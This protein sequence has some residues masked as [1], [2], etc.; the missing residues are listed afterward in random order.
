MI[1]FTPF[2]R[3][4]VNWIAQISRENHL[5][6]LQKVIQSLKFRKLRSKVKNALKKSV[7]AS[8]VLGK[9]PGGKLWK[10]RHTERQTSSFFSKT[11]SNKFFQ[12]LQSSPPVSTSSL[13][14]P[15]VL[16]G[17]WFLFP[18][19]FPGTPR[20]PDIKNTIDCVCL[21]SYIRQILPFSRFS[22][23]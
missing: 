2:R 4:A 23:L 13:Q 3:L 18:G 16:S 6:S 9:N 21:Q 7:P 22:P 5:D 12:C 11:I 8:F 1:C 17:P 10:I 20:C 15:F 19:A 14:L